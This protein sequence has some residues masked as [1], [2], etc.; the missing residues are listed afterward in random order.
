MKRS[1]ALVLTGV[2]FAAIAVCFLRP[3]KNP[4][5]GY[6][7]GTFG[8]EIAPVQVEGESKYF[9]EVTVGGI[10]TY[11]QSIGVKLQPAEPYYLLLGTHN[12]IY[13][14]GK[15]G[16]GTGYNSGHIDK[17][18]DGKWEFV[19]RTYRS[20][21]ETLEGGDDKYF[22]LSWDGDSKYGE[23]GNAFA[24]YA[25]IF[26]SPGEYRFTINFREVQKQMVGKASYKWMTDDTQSHSISFF[27]TVP[28]TTDKPFDVL[29]ASAFILNN[30][31]NHNRHIAYVVLRLN[32]G[33]P[34]PY[35]LRDGKYYPPA[36]D[37]SIRYGDEPDWDGRTVVRYGIV[38]SED[39]ADKCT[40]TFH[41]AE[42]SDGS[43]KQ[44]DLTLNLRF[45]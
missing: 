22:S 9:A 31:L 7:N 10:N 16:M 15:R 18:V 25:P 3:D 44:Y 21:Y 14:N 2:I 13:D 33:T 11:E 1:V 17:L 41:F 43:G 8:G 37:G 38:S 45:K 26:D 42:N 36:W 30:E 35:V 23:H 19:S 29:E 20:G 32:N 5:F 28:E 24:F 12:E 27:Y 39:Y 4:D 34:A 40:K 6:A